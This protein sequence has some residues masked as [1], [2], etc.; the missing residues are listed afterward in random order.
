MRTALVA[1]LGHVDHGKTALVRALTGIETDRLPE[2]KARGISIALGFARLALADGGEVD[3]VDAPGHE[4]FVRTMIAGASG[5]DA[6][7]L[8]VDAREG[9]RAQTR[10]HA[11]IA[12]LLGI[13]RG[14]V[15][16][17]RSDLATPEQRAAAAAAAGTLLAD[18]GLG[19]WP[20]I[21]TSARTGEGIDDLAAALGGLARESGAGSGGAWL[22]LDRAF[23]LPGAGVVVTGT[24][25]RGELALDDAVDLL[26]G[27]RSATIRGLHV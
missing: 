4:R 11:E 20:V 13:R 16:V 2:E 18:L 15:A 22:P 17:A 9:V 23:T 26:P 12:A 24:L 7:L 21:P 8:V 14:I 25:R 6:A 1:V 3:L 5:M 10:E 19:T 27:L